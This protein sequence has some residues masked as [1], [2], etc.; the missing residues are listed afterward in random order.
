[1]ESCQDNGPLIAGML[2]QSELKQCIPF[3]PKT[4]APGG[5]LRIRN[6][7]IDSPINKRVRRGF[8]YQN[9]IKAYIPDVL[10]DVQNICVKHPGSMYST[11]DASCN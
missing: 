5:Y 8:C 10:P 4:A 7:G 11:R 1:M 3:M 9:W 2:A 6:Y